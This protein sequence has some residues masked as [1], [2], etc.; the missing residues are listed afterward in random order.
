[1]AL[2]RDCAATGLLCSSTHTQ[3]ARIKVAA[4]YE[5]YE[6]MR[7]FDSDGSG[8]GTRVAIKEGQWRRLFCGLCHVKD[9]NML[10]WKK[11]SH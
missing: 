5:K 4:K 3:L 7:R 6:M 1:M 9:V 8:N 10:N 11:Y 2:Y